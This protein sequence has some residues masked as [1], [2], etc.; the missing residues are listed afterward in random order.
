M[1]LGVQ[2]SSAFF[3][4][5]KPTEKFRAEVFITFQTVVH[6]RLVI[7]LQMFSGFVLEIMDSSNGLILFPEFHKQMFV[8]IC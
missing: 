4:S 8:L 5:G 6:N 2:N 1:C 3:A 7:D